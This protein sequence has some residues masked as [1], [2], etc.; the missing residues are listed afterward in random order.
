MKKL[1][2]IFS[3][4]LFIVLGFILYR[5]RYQEQPNNYAGQ[6]LKVVTTLYP[7]YDFTK[8][9]GGDFVDV[10]LLLPPGVEAHVFEPKPFDIVRIHQADVFIYSGAVMEPWVEDVLQGIQNKNL[11]VV[12]TSDGIILQSDAAKIDPHYWLDFTNAIKMSSM[13]SNALQTKD[14]IHREAYEKNTSEVINEL[15][16]L[17]EEYQTT[18]VSC[19]T[20]EIVYGGHYAFGYLA[21]RY[22]L[23]YRAAL[24]VSPDAEP[25]AQDLS[26][27]IEYVRAHAIQYIF[28][29]EL[30]S[31]KIA[32]VLANETHTK[33]LLLN[34][35][36]NI[37]KTQFEQNVSFITI[38]KK[39][40]ENLKIGLSCQ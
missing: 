24:G 25:T 36:H 9:I 10:T 22:G 28:Y 39:N 29:E 11:L 37:S 1:L 34:G 6:R 5:I 14:P 18:L 31:P 8:T 26:I 21:K 15:R 30:T 13:I 20:N 16:N 17:D 23:V 40:L 12:N 38:M 2:L 4:F 3:V 32:E 7:L 33:L 35:A 19:K 27:L